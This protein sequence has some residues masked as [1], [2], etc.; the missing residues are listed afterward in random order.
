ML[1][2]VV[3]PFW[4]ERNRDYVRHTGYLA[5]LV[6]S[7]AGAPVGYGN[8]GF[9]MFALSK[10]N[11]FMRVLL[12]IAIPVTLRIV[13]VGARNVNLIARIA[14][15]VAVGV[16]TVDRHRKPHAAVRIEY[17]P[18]VKSES[19]DPGCGQSDGVN[20]EAVQRSAVQ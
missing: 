4:S 8:F 14:D 20:P 16:R 9:R 10:D 3:V 18:R 13:R 19:L 6:F 5:I 11:T 2:L 12:L 1:S 17:D 7:V 15:A